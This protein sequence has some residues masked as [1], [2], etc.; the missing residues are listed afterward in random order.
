MIVTCPECEGEG[1]I[2]YRCESC[3]GSGEDRSGYG[4]CSVCRGGGIVDHECEVCNGDGM[5]QK[6]EDADES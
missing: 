1:R 4:S 6:E 3:G 5:V 2:D